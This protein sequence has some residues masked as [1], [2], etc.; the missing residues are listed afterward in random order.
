MAKPYSEEELAAFERQA[1]LDSQNYLAQIERDEARSAAATR[2]A[3][4]ASERAAGLARRDPNF[5]DPNRPSTWNAPDSPKRTTSDIAAEIQPDY[6]ALNEARDLQS[7]GAASIQARSEAA[8]RALGGGGSEA[9]RLAASRAASG[10]TAANDAFT[11]AGQRVVTSRAN[12]AAPSTKKMVGTMLGGQ[13]EVVTDPFGEPVPEMQAVQVPIV[14]PDG[15]PMIDPTNPSGPPLMRTEMRPTGRVQVR[16]AQGLLQE[17]RQAA[18]AQG[19]AAI[20][21]ARLNTQLLQREADT[22]AALTQQIQQREQARQQ[23]AEQQRQSVESA[24]REVQRANLDLQ[25]AAEI[26]PDKGWAEKGTAAKIAAVIASGLLGFA[27]MDPFAHIRSVIDDSIAAQKA[28]QDRLRGRVDSAQGVQAASE[29]L[30]GQLR[31]QLGDEALADEAY[32]LTM[33]QDIKAQSQA[34]LSNAQVNELSAAQAAFMNGLDQQIAETQRRLEL[35]AATTPDRIYSSR[36]PYT[37]EQRAMLKAEHAAGLKAVESGGAGA[38]EA[39]GKR[40]ADERKISGDV[41]K[42]RIKGMQLSDADSK[43]LMQHVDN[44]QA[45]GALGDLIADFNAD[46]AGKDIPGRGASRIVDWATPND[47]A[48]AEVKLSL[49]EDTIGRLQSG[50][51]ITDDEAER[52]KGWIRAGVGDEQL[53]KNLANIERLAQNR[54]KRSERALP[55]HISAQYRRVDAGALPGIESDVRGRTGRINR[56]EGDSGVVAEDE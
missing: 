41:E 1:E 26:D 2:Q 10:R 17:G 44:T 32:R 48:D 23:R 21:T 30:L 31:T 24:Y 35:T 53:L 4:A 12:P 27:G 56:A 13:T 55:D 11:M 25:N 50:G 49:I 22:Q 33:L 37:P 42:E 39:I 19:Q 54:V 38:V 9:E 3:I 51:A 43:L 52:F 6:S 28:N 34:K 46:Y 20:D 7:A 14:G 45:A 18:Q 8:S 5:Y 15:Q 29:N 16:Q 36:S 40:E 47:V